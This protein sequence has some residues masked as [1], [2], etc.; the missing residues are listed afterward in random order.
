MLW[1]RPQSTSVQRSKPKRAICSSSWTFHPLPSIGRQSRLSEAVIAWVQTTNIALDAFNDNTDIVAWATALT[2]GTP[3]PDVQVQ[4]LNS[5]SAAVTD[6]NGV[7][8]IALPTT[9]SSL[10]VATQGE[11][12]AILPRNIY[13]WYD[14]GWVRNTV[15]DEVRWFVFRRP[16]HVSPW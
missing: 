9:P 3:L 13:P 7:A 16:R 2:D 8:H 4:L 1:W 11:D 10:L 6:E 15:Q 5:E 14:N 12:V